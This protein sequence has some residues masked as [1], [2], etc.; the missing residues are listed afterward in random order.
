MKIPT[1]IQSLTLQKLIDGWELIID[2]EQIY[3][4]KFE[5]KFRAYIPRRSSIA[6]HTI[7]CE[8][9]KRKR[10]YMS[11]MEKYGWVDKHDEGWTI[12]EKGR[13]AMIDYK[14]YFEV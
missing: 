4:R 3:W 1:V 9:P 11:H 13:Q 2:N 10:Y 5:P 14:N 8:Q 7:P 6:Y 12:T